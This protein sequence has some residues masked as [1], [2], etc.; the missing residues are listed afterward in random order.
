[1]KDH[2]E[3]SRTPILAAGGIVLRNDHDLAPQF[4]VVQSRKLQTWG[5]PKGKLAAGEDAMAAA[6]RE[7]LEE[8]GRRVTVHEF[9]GTLVYETGSRPKVIQFWRMQAVGERAGDLMRDVVAVDWLVLEDAV[10]RL[11][12]LR[13]QVFLEQVGPIALKL[14]ERAA[15]SA[16]LRGH[17][18]GSILVTPLAPAADA[19]LADNEG[20]RA[21]AERAESQLL[22]RDFTAHYAP[23]ANLTSA[24]VNKQDLTVQVAEME[25]VGRMND[26]YAPQESLAENSLL[27]G[28]TLVKKTWGWFRHAALLGWRP[29]D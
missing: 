10:N 13:E 3:K 19:F 29:P 7:V 9:L 14:A 1:M 24:I 27:P 21:P 8:T 11:T 2:K 18:A 23:A 4:A 22:E 28:K 5:L 17:A 12:H 20:E 25:A 16:L 15:R 26:K 6:R